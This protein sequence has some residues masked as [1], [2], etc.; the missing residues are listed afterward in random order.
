MSD[1]SVTVHNFEDLLTGKTD[2]NGFVSGEV[3]IF[4]AD[5]AK[6]PATAQAFVGA[7]VASLEV[8]ASALVGAGKTALG[9]L[10][11]AKTDDQ[12]TMVLNLLNAAGVP[13][14]GAV[15]N[16]AEHAALD[17]IIDGLKAGLDRVGIRVATSGV[18]APA[19]ST[20]KAA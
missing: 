3:A 4:K 18:N 6:L 7:A 1:L 14:G 12:A 20:A 5:V 17:A 2:F 9:P 8:K 16:V 11:A 10:I 19:A 13:T 15:L